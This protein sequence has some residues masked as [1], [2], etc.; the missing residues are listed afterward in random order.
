[1]AQFNYILV[2][3]EE[4]ESKKQVGCYSMPLNVMFFEIQKLVRTF[5]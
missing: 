1:L 5:K 3:G 4:E 2:V